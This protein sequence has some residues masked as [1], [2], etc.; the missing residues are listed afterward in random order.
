MCATQWMNLYTIAIV[1][2]FQSKNGR[3]ALLAS[4]TDLRKSATWLISE[5]NI[6]FDFHNL[7]IPVGY[8]KNTR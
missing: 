3:Q 4:T 5:C 6:F 8:S 1:H 2:T 7:V